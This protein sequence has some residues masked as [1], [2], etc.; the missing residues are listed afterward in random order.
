[1][2]AANDQRAAGRQR[3][4]TRRSCCAESGRQRWCI[5]HADANAR[6]R[7]PRRRIGEGE[8]HR[9]WDRHSRFR[10]R[11][12]AGVELNETARARHA[13]GQRRER[14]RIAEPF[15]H[16]G[17]EPDGRARTAHRR[18]QPRQHAADHGIGLR[19]AGQRHR[20]HLAGRKP[21]RLGQRSKSRFLRRRR[22]APARQ[23]ADG[24]E[25]ISRFCRE[26]IALGTQPTR[27]R[28]GCVA[29]GRAASERDQVQRRRSRGS[30]HVHGTRP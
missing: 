16:H 20:Q 19:R 12:A 4:S 9:Q 8:H 25:H 7:E 18:L 15:R 24:I 14:G 21:P 1:M 22:Q 27:L 28:A 30:S 5:D 3:P 13:A 29:V 17:D 26:R 11:A 23:L 10:Q 2:T 6:R